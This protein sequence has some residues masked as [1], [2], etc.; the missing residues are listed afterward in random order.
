MTVWMQVAGHTAANGLCVVPH[1]GDMMQIHQYLV[2]TVLTESAP[3]VEC[4]LW[5]QDAFEH[6]SVRRDGFLERP[7]AP[8]ASTAIS[9]RAREKWQIKG[10]G[11]TTS[12]D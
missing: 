10:V 4:I 3:L 12:Q 9:P 7:Q 6:G 1:A 11:T 8:G 5:T 2:G